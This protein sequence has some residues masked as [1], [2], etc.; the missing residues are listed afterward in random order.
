MGSLTGHSEIVSLEIEAL[1]AIYGDGAVIWLPIQSSSEK[2]SE[3]TG[4]QSLGTLRILV[5]PHEGCFKE[6]Y[7][8]EEEI[9]RKITIDFSLP[10]E[11]PLVSP[12]CH[13]CRGY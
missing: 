6:S 11:Y 13:V 1:T 10:V 3:L 8:D 7:F 5:D 12:E 2:Q 4:S 9:G